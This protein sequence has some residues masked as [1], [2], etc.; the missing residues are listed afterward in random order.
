MSFST[1]EQAI[2]A[3]ANGEMII[4]V[5]DEDRENEGD[6]LVAADKITD[7]HVAFMMRHARGLICVPLTGER[8]D[9]LQIPLMVTRNSESLQTA[10]TVSVDYNVGTTTGISAGDRA[11]TI[12]ALTAP[13]TRADEMAR[14]G[15]IFPLRANPLGVLG[16]PGHTE[17]AIDF[18]RL[19]GFSPAGVICEI[20]NDDGTMSRLPELKEFAALH[21]LH[22]VT[23][24][25]LIEYRKASEPQVKRYSESQMPTRF[26][27]FQAIVYRDTT[28]GAEHIAFV[29]GDVAG[30]EDVPVRV[31][32]E[33]LTGEA[34]RSLRC[35]CGEQLEMAMRAVRH[36]G[37]GCVIYLRG[38][39]GRGIGLGNK[40]AAYGLQD[41]GMDTL[42]ANSALGLPL[43][44]RQY[45]AA[46]DILS[47]LGIVSVKLLTNN[48]AK[49]DALRATGVSVT[50]R[51]SLIVATSP[52]NISYLRAKRDRFGHL[53]GKEEVPQN[54]ADNV[55]QVWNA[56]IS[57]GPLG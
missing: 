29:Y 17:A 56:R 12:R 31:H 13:A 24:E 39:E 47:D 8:L 35:D 44:T 32:S 22:I 40:I 27:D 25:A 11:A 33:C 5:D 18:A 46:A 50:S 49:L 45:D 1:I 48:P 55:I 16:R 7:E 21:G 14:P 41:K 38:Q 23:I 19:A 28:S 3:I 51:Q 30:R 37:E 15:H 9:E 53:L 52:S 54:E 10:F 2:Q 36:A 20:A 42:D 34:F 6:I 4:V 26:G 43:D 57:A